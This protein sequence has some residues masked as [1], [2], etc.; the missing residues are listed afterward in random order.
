[1]NV[2]VTGAAG[3]LGRALQAATKDSSR[4]TYIFTDING[5]YERLDIC[6]EEAVTL[7]VDSLNIE[8]IVNCA[9][10]TDVDRAEGQ[11]Q[12]LCR[13]LNAEAPGIL[14]RA[15]K[16]KGGTLFHIS[17]DYVF[18]REP[19]NKPCRET[20]TGTPTG[21]YGQTKLLGE[22]A[23]REAGC[24]HIII[25]TAWLYSEYGKNF[26]LTML[27]LT[28][29]RP[30]VSVV[31][32]QC[33]TPTYALHL[34]KAIA[35]IIDGRL[36]E[37]HT[38]TYHYSNEGVCSWYDFA[39]AIAQMARRNACQV[40]PCHSEDYPSPVVRP[41]YSVLDKTLIKQTFSLTIPHWRDALAECL[42][43]LN[44]NAPKK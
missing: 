42:S 33:G 38:G 3:Q 14:A 24:K 1:M 5:P 20:Q 18:G 34:A 22:Q 21:V 27:R 41:A 36:S 16:R 37:G 25:R 12:E 15:M 44:I 17:T 9:A 11:G 6:D 31:F 39:H 19:Y 40:T 32:D 35:S 8:C 43:N 23:I 28:A 13:K 2:L 29:T 26:L 30:Q 4:D 10:Y 7:A